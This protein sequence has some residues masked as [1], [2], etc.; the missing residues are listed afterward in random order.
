MGLG[1]LTGNDF[2]SIHLLEQWEN[3]I[4]QFQIIQPSVAVTEESSGIP[5]QSPKHSPLWALMEPAIYILI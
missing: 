2:N 3:R 1:N 4:C 5:I